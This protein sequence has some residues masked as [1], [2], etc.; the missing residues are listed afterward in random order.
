MHSNNTIKNE[1]N[2]RKPPKQLAFANKHI[3]GIFIIWEYKAKLV[4]SIIASL[5]QDDNKETLGEAG[6]IRK[7]L[8]PN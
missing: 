8:T 3:T 7:G 5:S 4:L 1:K 2:S 6:V